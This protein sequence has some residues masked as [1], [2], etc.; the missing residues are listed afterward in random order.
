ME[1]PVS[2]HIEN[3]ARELYGALT[4]LAGREVPW[5]QLFSERSGD[6][7][8]LTPGLHDPATIAVFDFVRHCRVFI[9]K[10]CMVLKLHMRAVGVRRHRSDSRM[11]MKALGEAFE[12]DGVKRIDIE[13]DFPLEQGIVPTIAALLI[14]PVAIFAYSLVWTIQW[15]SQWRD[16]DR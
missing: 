16:R 8:N 4:A 15:F 2:N 13:E 6:M 5:E 10:D 3:R 9:S 1:V 14:S 11:L 12:A 7:Q